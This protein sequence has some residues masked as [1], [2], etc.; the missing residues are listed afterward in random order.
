MKRPDR[1]PRPLSRLASLSTHELQLTRATIKPV[2]S[3]AVQARLASLGRLQSATPFTRRAPSAGAHA[4]GKG[5][6]TLLPSIL[7]KAFKGKL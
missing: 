4:A 6:S 7:D 1:F 2:R 5:L 3:D